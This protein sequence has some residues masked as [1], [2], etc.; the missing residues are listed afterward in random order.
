MIKLSEEARAAIKAADFP[1]TSRST[2]EAEDSA[3][4]AAEDLRRSL[5]S[6][7]DSAEQLRELTHQ[8]QE[9]PE[10][11]VYGRRAPARNH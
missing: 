10:S 9:E 5:S 11:F 8:I 6:V 1:A 3:R 2:R 7:R 4:L